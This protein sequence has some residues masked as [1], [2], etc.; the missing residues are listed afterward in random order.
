MEN[1]ATLSSSSKYDKEN[2]MSVYGAKDIS[3]SQTRSHITDY[4]MVKHLSIM[5]GKVSG[6]PI[7]AS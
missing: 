5:L 7:T 2:S 1:Y 4:G 3:D 6:E